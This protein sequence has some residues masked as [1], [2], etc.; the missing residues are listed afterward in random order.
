MSTGIGIDTCALGDDCHIADAVTWSSNLLV[1]DA[2]AGDA[3]VPAALASY[4]D[5]RR[6][7]VRSVMRTAHVEETITFTDLV[8]V[9]GIRDTVVQWTPLAQWFLKRQF[10]AYTSA[11]L[12]DL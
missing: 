4:E 9:A 6:D 3:P 1:N 12:E 8:V 10:D 7:R 5:R 11:P 2:L